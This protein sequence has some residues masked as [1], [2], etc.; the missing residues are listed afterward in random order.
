ME[1]LISESMQVNLPGTT[2]QY[3]NWRGRLTMSLETIATDP[4]IEAIIQ[5]VSEGRREAEKR[6]ITKD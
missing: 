1:N 4:K 6:I 3:P 5:A 2:N